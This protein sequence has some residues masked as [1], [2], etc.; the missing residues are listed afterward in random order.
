MQELA[1][2]MGDKGKIATSPATRTPEL[3]KR[4]EG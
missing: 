2:Q 4:V 1:K 3:Q